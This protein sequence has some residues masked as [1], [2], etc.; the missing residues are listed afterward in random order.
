MT[1]SDKDTNK[2]Y[3]LRKKNKLDKLR[4]KLEIFVMSMKKDKLYNQFKT[5]L[6][7]V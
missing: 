7:I 5:G 3:E 1:E 2:L 4:K 6:K